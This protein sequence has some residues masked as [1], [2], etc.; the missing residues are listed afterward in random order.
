MKVAAT[1]EGL[2]MLIVVI[3]GQGGGVGRNIIEALLPLIEPEHSLLALG[4]NSLATAAMLKAGA[5]QGASGENAII[6]NVGRADLIV[7]PIGILTAN[8]LLGEL[9]E[10]MAVAIARSP[11]QKILLPTSRCGL[12]VVGVKEKKL[13]ELIPLTTQK[14][15]EIINL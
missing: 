14:V 6:Y 13:S 1:Q 12:H 3:D 2:E 7:G 5:K 9:S 4:T 11:A 8:S 10:R 15:A